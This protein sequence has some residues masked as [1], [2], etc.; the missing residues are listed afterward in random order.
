MR[1]IL[2]FLD[3]QSS[4]PEFVIGSADKRTELIDPAFVGRDDQ[5]ETLEQGLEHALAGGQQHIMMF[6]QSGMGKTRLLTEI[7][8]VAARKG[9][10][11]LHGRSSNHAAQEPNA[12]L[13]SNDRSAGKAL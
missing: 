5:M 1:Q 4:P 3:R 13:A 9:F 7:S 12:P 11:I 2:N 8:R 10:L 6:S